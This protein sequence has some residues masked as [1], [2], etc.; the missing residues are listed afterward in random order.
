MSLWHFLNY[1]SNYDYLNLPCFTRYLFDVITTFAKSLLMGGE[2]R[3]TLYMDGS[4]QITFHP[5]SAIY[6]YAILYSS[7]FTL[8]FSL[9]L[10][11]HEYI[12]KRH[13]TVTNHLIIQTT[14][15]QWMNV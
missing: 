2:R 1:G 4:S 13:R 12:S 5:P 8:V 15:C 3:D 14:V 7:Y 11:L 10:S 9:R 6:T